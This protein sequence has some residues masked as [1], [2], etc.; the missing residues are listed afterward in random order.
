MI[1]SNSNT[2]LTTALVLAFI[3]I[4]Y[5]AHI[6]MMHKDG[7][8]QPRWR[9][10]M[11]GDSHT[12]KADKTS[13]DHTNNE[14]EKPCKDVYPFCA[15]LVRLPH[16]CNTFASSVY[17]QC[18][19]SC[20]LCEHEKDQVEVE[21]QLMD[22]T[23]SSSAVLKKSQADEQTSSESDSTTSTSDST[24][25]DTSEAKVSDGMSETIV[26]DDASEA[27]ASDVSKN[28]DDTAA[29]SQEQTVHALYEE[30]VDENGHSENEYACQDLYDA[31]NTIRGYCFKFPWLPMMEQRCRK[32]CGHC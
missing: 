7:N 27:K 14:I 29:T 30:W 31:C 21:K 28:S 23:A 26:S 19:F 18:R 8:S 10:K 3:S 17:K 4:T 15:E 5:A 12:D 6:S 24:S 20:N 9:M 16:V 11:V 1:S 32:T 25:D 22:L 2:I 13:N